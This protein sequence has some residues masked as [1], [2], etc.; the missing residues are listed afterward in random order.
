MT[1]VLVVD[2]S[3]TDRTLV[4]G[5]LGSKSGWTIESAE[6]GVEA[7][8]RMEQ[9]TPDVVVTDMQMPGMDG[10]RLVTAV[11]RRY[12][13][14]PVI[15]MTAFGSEALAVEA[16]E[17]GAASYVPK[18]QLAQKLVNTVEKVMALGRAERNYEELVGC[19]TESQFTLSLPNDAE[20]IDPLVDLVQRLVVGIGFCDYT[21][22]LQVG[23]ALKEAL[24]NALLHG[25]LELSVNQMQDALDKLRAGETVSLVHDPRLDP[26]VRDRR[27]DVAVSLSPEEVR[28]VVRDQGSG[29]DVST[30]PNSKDPSALEAG[31]GRGLAIMRNLMDEVTFNESGNQVTLIKRRKAAELGEPSGDA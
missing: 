7:L 28:F 9:A 6:D 24:L 30:V 25:S 20:L 10:L 5:L 21:E 14:V 26:A 29:F 2:D 15:L 16:L 27:I 3:A 1:T 8:S 23:M 12:P 17:K 19:M 13:G 18:Q 31:R 22:G 4:S 11:R